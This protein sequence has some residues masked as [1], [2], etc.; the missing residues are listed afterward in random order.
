LRGKKKR[1]KCFEGEKEKHKKEKERISSF[2]LFCKKKNGKRGEKQ[3]LKRILCVTHFSRVQNGRR[4]PKKGGQKKKSS[5]HIVVFF[6][7]PRFF[8]LLVEHR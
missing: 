2:F 6:L 4:K 1:K 7:C 8:L 3:N 5:K